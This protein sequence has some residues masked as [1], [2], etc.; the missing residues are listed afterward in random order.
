MLCVAVL[1]SMFATVSI[2]TE[3]TEEWSVELELLSKLGV[4]TPNYEPVFTLPRGELC[5]MII[6]CLYPETDFGGGDGKPVFDDV[7]PET[8]FY[9]EIRACKELKIINGSPD[10]TFHPARRLTA[11]EVVTMLLNAMQYT[12]YANAKGGY[13][14]GYLSVAYEIGLL[15][16]IDLHE[17]MTGGVIAK[18]V[19]NALFAD[20]VSVDS[21]TEN[22]I[23]LEVLPDK[24]LLSE[25]LGIEEYDARVIDNGVTSLAGDGLNDSQRVA[26][27]VTKTGEKITAY[28][29]ESDIFQHLGSRLKVYVKYD[30]ESG[31]NEVLTYHLHKMSSET[32]LNADRIISVTADYI[33]YEK[34]PE[35]TDYRKAALNREGAAVVL[36][37]IH[38]VNYTSEDLK[39][40]DGFLRI[41]D[42]DGDKRADLIEVLSFNVGDNGPKVPQRNLIAA[43]LNPQ[44]GYI[45]CKFNPSL[46]LT[47][48]ESKCGYRIVNS[49]E[50]RELS[51][52]AENDVIS[53]AQAPQ[54]ID[55]KAFYYLMVARERAEGVVD[56]IEESGNKVLVENNA[57]PVSD[58][59]LQV[60]PRFLQTLSL[61][62]SAVFLLDATGKIAYQKGAA[63]QSKEYAYLI[64]LT[65]EGGLEAL[66]GKFFLKT[67]EVKVCA[68]RDKVKVDGTALEDRAQIVQALMKRDP[69]SSPISGAPANI[70]AEQYSRPVLLKM[71]S[72]GQITEID[73]DNPNVTC[74]SDINYYTSEHCL[75]YTNEEVEDPAALKAGYRAPRTSEYLYRN[76]CSLSG[77]FYVTADTVIMNVPDIDVYGL[78]QYPNYATNKGDINFTRPFDYQMIQLYERPKEDASYQILS[79]SALSYLY[80]FDIQGYDIDP[81]TGVA[82]LAIVRG[83]ADT[84]RYGTNYT[85][86]DLNMAVFLRTSE[87]YDSAKEKKVKKIYYTTNGSDEMAA[88][89]DTDDMLFSYKYL[90]EGCQESETPYGKAVPALK[91][92]DII[93]ITRNGNNLAHLE[94]VF[95]IDEIASKAPAAGLYPS[96][97]RFLYSTYLNGI[98]AMPND[99]RAYYNGVNNQYT[100]T[101]VSPK[102]VSGGNLTSYLSRSTPDKIVLGDPSTYVMQ[103]GDISTAPILVVQTDPVSGEIKT[104]AGTYADIKTVEET[105]SVEKA[106]LV[107]QFRYDYKCSQIIV[108]NR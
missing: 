17:E 53:V 77:R 37:G 59:I 61:G 100:L 63:A 64:G 94:R 49:G 9:S 48:D 83:R 22:A 41:V 11:N 5:A 43:N 81:D 95:R 91:K 25:R 76:S 32:L 96:N 21:V 14:S 62:E 42:N 35:A 46:G 89:A 34:E 80:S 50:I 8:A 87:V 98:D 31:R 6:R 72:E 74:S 16:G 27:R 45:G 69:I 108:V 51:D 97:S 3:E 93:R 47:L 90:I 58:S 82:G 92:G 99:Q 33:E 65:D 30:K 26:L 52:I 19:Y 23:I 103:T 68:F 28:I 104:K 40:E 55:G 12:P 105:K 56:S 79:P 1:L 88:A 75:K 73:T 18:M 10:N 38:K 102:S 86:N 15:K 70:Y 20:L 106:S 84:F 2:A 39:P 24:N 29:G 71:N 66:K 54:E 36:N 7:T 4:L 101:V 13:P 107:I 85:Y 67:G 78:D 60:K 44:E 57:Y